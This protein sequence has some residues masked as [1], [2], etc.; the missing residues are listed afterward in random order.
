MIRGIQNKQLRFT[1]LA[2][3]ISL[4]LLGATALAQQ[5]PRIDAAKKSGPVSLYTSVSPDEM[6]KEL[7]AG[8]KDA[9]G[10]DV[11]IY[12]A[13]T[14]QTYSRIVSERKSGSRTV[15]VVTM[16]DTELIE[17]LVESKLL[18]PFKPKAEIAAVIPDQYRSPDGYWNAFAVVGLV[19]IYN[20][21]ALKENEAPREW[22]ALADP[23]WK[24]KLAISDPAKSASGLMMMKAMVNQQG[25][26]WVEKLYLN[27][28][29]VVSNG[30]GVDLAVASG[31]RVI[32]AAVT[33]FASNTVKSGAPV[34][35]APLE[36]LY[37]E[38]YTLSIVEGAP[39]PAGAELLIEYLL[40]AQA[41]KIFAKYGYH[42]TRTDAPAPYGF[43][44]LDKLNATY[45]R[46]SSNMPRAEYLSQIGKIA[47]QAR[48]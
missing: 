26:G 15:D 27:D 32:G 17:E 12:Y 3:S 23:K 7:A 16:A 10:L 4:T 36:S 20:S 48:R 30:P 25:W 5:D 9:T 18:K 31:E 34:K 45:S 42:S 44:S 35:V 33:G 38:P 37:L 29:L 43:P 2:G 40:S 11:G 28:P 8:F 47:Q 21:Q 13:G 19:L 14:G 24:S 6:R 39:N 22:A 1:A 41:S 46:V